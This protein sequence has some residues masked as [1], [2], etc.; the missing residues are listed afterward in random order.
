MLDAIAHALEQGDRVELRGFGAF[1]VRH[2]L[3]RSGRNPKNGET[4]SVDEKWVP[5]F[6]VGKEI[7]ERLNE[8]GDTRSRKLRS[9]D[10]D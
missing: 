7:R 2:R 4:V 10:A 5:L 8:I 1:F 9:H 3:A 6:R